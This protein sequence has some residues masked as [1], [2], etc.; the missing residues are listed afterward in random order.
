M[1]G[2]AV[3]DAKA[4]QQHQGLLEGASAQNQI[5]LSASRAALFE[6]D[7]R[8]LAQQ[9]LWR[10]QGESLAFDGQ[11]DDGG[12]GLGQG[13]RNRRTEDL[14]GLGGMRK[15]RDRKSVREGKRV[16]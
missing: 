2:L 10:L 7:R 8:I 1:R 6:K 5:N 12:G 11:H 9:L 13:H 3:V 16:D 15:L 14:H 4:V